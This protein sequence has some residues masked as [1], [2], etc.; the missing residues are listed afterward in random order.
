MGFRLGINLGWAVN[1]YPEPEVWAR[2]V[3][4]ELGLGHVQLVADLLNPFWPTDYLEDQ[5]RRIAAAC[6]RHDI[7]V[8]S[9]MT[10]SF[11]RVNHLLSPD[12]R[13]REFWQEWFTTLIEMGAR[14]GVRNVGSH[15]G[16]L[17]FS[18]FDDA[19]SQ[20][21]I[22]A[23]GVRGWQDLTRVA[24][25]FGLSELIFEPM[26]VPRELGNTVEETRELLDLVNQDAGVPLK[27]CL[28]VGHAPHPSQRDP[29]PWLVALASESP[30]IHL[31]QTVLNASR[32]APFTAENNATGIITRERVMD[33]VA[34]SGASD[35]LFAF[36]ISHREH[37]DSDFR[38]VADLA[39]S[40]DYWR[41]VIPT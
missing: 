6:E 36:E 18:S 38:V 1:R 24:A 30:C 5:V 12:P 25:S 17:T 28:D 3:R 41:P 2:I 11:T 10:S 26:S 23:A 34:A 15:F 16:I 39:E 4:E 35:A 13:A 27:V 8:E 19:T 22:L 14:L 31:Q 40:V 32:H 7:L 9:L 21:T 33:A 29:Y 20:G 37:W